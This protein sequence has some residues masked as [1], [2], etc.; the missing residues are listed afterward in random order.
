MKLRLRR[1]LGFWLRLRLRLVLRRKG[2]SWLRVFERRQGGLKDGTERS[3][4]GYELL[5]LLELDLLILNGLRVR[6]V[7]LD[8]PILE[9]LERFVSRDVLKRG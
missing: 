3:G 9:N 6:H 7:L 4:R 8:L 2:L 5:R 1:W